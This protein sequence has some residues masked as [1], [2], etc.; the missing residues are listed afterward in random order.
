[1]RHTKAIYGTVLFGESS[2]ISD[3]FFFFSATVKRT[4]VGIG[5]QC[6]KCLL[7]SIGWIMVEQIVSVK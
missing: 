1:M 6:N 3:F 2:F 4:A 5:S 7:D